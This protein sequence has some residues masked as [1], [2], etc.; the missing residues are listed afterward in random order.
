MSRRRRFGFGG[1]YYPS[2][3][4]AGPPAR[5]Y[6]GGPVAYPARYSRYGGG[7]AGGVVPGGYSRGVVPGGYSQ[8]MVPGSFG[9][10]RHSGYSYGYAY[11]PGYLTGARQLMPLHSGAVSFHF[12][13]SLFLFLLSSDRGTLVPA[14]ITP[15]LALPRYFTGSGV[16]W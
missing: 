12:S 3:Y 16:T 6:V 14:F 7:Y 10:V 5:R 4:Y 8:A 1:S 15:L 13:F 9:G 2:R 11:V